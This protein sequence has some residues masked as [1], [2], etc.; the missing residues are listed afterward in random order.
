MPPWTC[1]PPSGGAPE[2][3]ATLAK[4]RSELLTAL[5]GLRS[6]LVCWMFGFWVTT[7]IGVAGLLIAL[8]NR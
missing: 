3:P 2:E 7:F 1:R 5:A 6:E 4:L 8:G